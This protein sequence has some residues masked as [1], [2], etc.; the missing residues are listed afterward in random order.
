MWD[1]LK[2]AYQIYKNG[3]PKP[4]VIKEK[5]Q[6]IYRRRG[7]AKDYAQ[8][9]SMDGFVERHIQ[10][11]ASDDLAPAL[12]KLGMDAAIK[13]FIGSNSNFSTISEAQLAWYSSQGFIG[14]QT[15]GIL[16]QQWLINRACSLP[17]ID[18]VR[19]GFEISINDGTKIDPEIRDAIREGDLKYR[20]N[21]NL[22]QYE[23][24]CRIYGIRI[25]Y[26]KVDSKD[27][28]YYEKPFNLDGVTPGS[29][30]GMVQVDPYWITPELDA[31]A[32]GN[33]ASMYFYEPTWWRVN[34]QRIHRTHL[35]IARTAELPDILKPTYFYGGIPIPQMI[36]DRVYAAERTANEAPQLAMTKRLMVLKTDMAAA[37]ANEEDFSDRLNFFAKIR[38]NYG[39]KCI[40]NA[41]EVEQ[42][43]TS[44]ADLND[45]IM[46]QYQLVAAASGVPATK[47]LGTTPKGFNAT[48]EYDERSYHET[49][50]SIQVSHL[51]PVIERHHDLLIRSEILPDMPFSTKVIWNKASTLSDEQ[52]ASINESKAR[53]GQTLITS[54]AIDAQDER[55][56]IIND[57]YSGYSGLEDESS[58]SNPATPDIDS[59]SIDD[60]EEGKAGVN[61]WN[62][63]QMFNE[64]D[65]L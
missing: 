32:A 47:I 1:R 23:R 3:L 27:P 61:E 62:I 16:A 11:N 51:T 30:R 29:Y 12:K 48:G 39:I 35:M 9:T 7:F 56:R 54:G 4:E 31:E 34:D 58:E 60:P 21:Y 40:D 37:L 36:L 19:P 53:A 33:P 2:L 8:I 15:A 5:P 64:N 10:R 18:A 28:K 43:D 57:P 45:V 13:P 46:T 42:Y 17:G 25:M 6:G 65:L 55:E 22:E 20:L 41:D 26:F 49:L 59:S 50:E 14:Y 52:I 24:F 63:G 38:D 44:L